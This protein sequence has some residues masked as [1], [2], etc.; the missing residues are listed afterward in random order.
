M[1][2]QY[3]E[4][5]YTNGGDSGAGSRGRLAEWKASQI[6]DFVA[7]QSIQSVIEFGC[8]DG[9]QLALSQ[10]PKY[11]GYDI[12][13]AAVDLCKAKVKRQ[14]YSI[15][16]LAQYSGQTAQ[17]ALSVDVIFHLVDN[18]EYKQY[19]QMLTAAADEWLIVYSTDVDLAGPAPHVKHRRFSDM[20]A[21]FDLI[22]TRQPPAGTFCQ[23]FI[24]RRAQ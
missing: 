13:P 24:Y 16:D 12:S 18:D 2:K 23:L 19:M 6:N 15:K 4:Q 1:N 20:L 8:G 11:Q 17:L 21:G 22:E 5:R 9:Q 14:G 7:E 3:W 10:Y